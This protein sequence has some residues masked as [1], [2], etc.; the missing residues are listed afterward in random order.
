MVLLDIFKKYNPVVRKLYIRFLKP[1]LRTDEMSPERKMFTGGTLLTLSSL[2]T[3]LIFSKPVAILSLYVLTVCDS[4]SAIAGKSIGKHKFINDKTLE[5]TL[6]FILSGVVIVLIMPL[7]VTSNIYEYIIGIICVILS[8]G[9][10]LIN[11]KIDDNIT[12]PLFFGITY[13]LFCKIFI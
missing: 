8:S 10:E 13:T 11:V 7:K 4:F 6:A 1:V 12:I 3:I 5:G 2:L 9:L